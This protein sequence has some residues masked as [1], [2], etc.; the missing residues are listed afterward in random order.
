MSKILAIDL[1]TG[2]SCMAIM[3]NGKAT[4]IA[5]AEG[6]RTTPSVVAWNKN[7]ERIVGS[8][9][10]RQA[11]SNPK[12]T[13]YEVK[14]MI[15]RKYDEVRDEI[16]N[17]PY[18]VVR[19]SNGDCRIVVNGKEYSPEEISS[20]VLAK[21]RADAEAYAGESITQAIITCPAYFNDSQR[22]A[23]KAAG[24]IAGLTVL[25]V[26]NEPTA[27]ALAYGSGKDKN[28]VIAVADSGSGTLDFTILEISDG[29]FE[30][31]ST[32][33]D[34]QLG[35]KDYD[36][37]V[38]TFLI[39]DFK[40]ETGIDLSLDPMALQRVKDEAEKAKIAL[41][42]ATSYDIN[43]P[44]ITMDATGPK[45][46]MKNLT[47]AK[48]EQLIEPLNDRYDTPAKQCIKDAGVVHIDEVILV[49]GTTRIPSV[50]RKI[51][52]IFGLEPSKGV[53]PDEAVATG[54]AVQSGVMQ[55]DVT[56]I[57][58]LDVTPLTLSIETMGEIATPM[59]DRNTTIPVK[60][61]QVFSTASDNQSAVTIRVAQGERKM[62]ADNKILGS[63][64]L[65]GIDPAPRGVP[66]IEVTFDIDA[67]GI[68]KVSAKDKN[69]GKEQ[70]ITITNSS[71][72]S[73]EEIARAKKEAEEHAEEDK[74]RQE[75]AEVRNRAE[76]LVHNI[77]KMLSEQGDKVP[78]DVKDALNADITAIREAMVGDDVERTKNLCAELEQK[79][80]KAAEMAQ[81][82]NAEFTKPEAEEAPKPAEDSDD[83]ID[84]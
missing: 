67:N 16:K 80:A 36:Q 48:L 15:G 75:K 73:K 33:G 27:A 19:A 84:V 41:S 34:S 17:L 53:N 35:G 46:L 38:M 23:T 82:A 12:G 3:E 45:H 55:G 30:V 4:V 83:V 20:F 18:E 37:A 29:V 70:T 26:I 66:Q 14:R 63:F 6:E 50:Q 7:G 32:A 52:D 42:S 11:V 57:L 9:A 49:G 64:N 2:N 40:A 69:T 21:L 60:K 43:L 44:F 13:V 47:R 58:L 1:G 78:T 77:E 31:L 54:A 61:S 76:T 74:K 56:G 59:I 62:F 22:A 51:A 39:N 79:L 68:L 71:G 5:N 10:K 72:L 81:Q 25:R 8:P 28:G 24:E 65:E